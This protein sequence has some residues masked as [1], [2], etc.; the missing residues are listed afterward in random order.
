MCYSSKWATSDI[1]IILHR[2]LW[3]QSEM[4][5]YSFSFDLLIEWTIFSWNLIILGF[6]KTPDLLIHSARCVML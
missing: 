1:L 5:L 4:K 3:I 2:K 6:S